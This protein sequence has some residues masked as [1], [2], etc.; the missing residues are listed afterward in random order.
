M[1]SR[2]S[3]GANHGKKW[4]PPS[5]RSIV[6]VP[7]GLSALNS[8][9]QRYAPPQARERTLNSIQAVLEVLHFVFAEFTDAALDSSTGELQLA[10]VL[11][12][13][14]QRGNLF[15]GDPEPRCTESSPIPHATTGMAG[16]PTHGAGN[17]VLLTFCYA[18]T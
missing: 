18:R 11:E 10:R 8:L 16:P 4:S 14:G 15:F 17:F 7:K 12:A 5:K 13:A 9:P 2:Q 3:L 6:C 1:T